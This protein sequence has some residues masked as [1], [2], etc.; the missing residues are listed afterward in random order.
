MTAYVRK[1]EEKDVLRG[2]N[3]WPESNLYKFIDLSF[4]TKVLGIVNDQ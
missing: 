3:N 4:F 2:Y 1:G